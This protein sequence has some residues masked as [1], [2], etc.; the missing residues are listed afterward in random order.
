MRCRSNC[1]PRPRARRSG[2]RPCRWSVVPYE[3]EHLLVV[4]KPAGLVVHPAPGNWSGT[5]SMACWRATRGRRAAARRHRAPPGQ[6]HQRPD[7]GGA[8]PPAMDALVKLIAARDVTRQYLALAHRRWTGPSPATSRRPSAAT[9][10]TACAWPSS[11]WPAMPARPPHHLRPGGGQRPGLPGARQPAHRPHAP[12]PRAHG[13]PRPSAGGRRAVW[14]RARRG[15]AAPGAACVPAGLHAPVHGRRARPSLGAARRLRRRACRVGPAL[16]S[17][18]TAGT[19]PP[20]RRPPA[21]PDGAAPPGPP[22]T[23]APLAPVPRQERP[24]EYRG[25]QAR[26]RNRA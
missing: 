11:T 24:D 21:Q 9:R 10:A 16:Q 3:D 25:C 20:A 15:H 12:D 17:G 13:A 2:P 26:P 5:C 1:G 22:A 6:G 18:C 4:D 7:G 19:R 23:A 8:H 14:R